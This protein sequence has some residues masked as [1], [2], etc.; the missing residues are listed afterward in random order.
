[1]IFYK[2]CNPIIHLGRVMLYVWSSPPVVCLSWRVPWAS[3][4][5]PATILI[6]R[7]LYHTL[8]NL[9]PSI[10]RGCMNTLVQWCSLVTR[11]YSNM[12]RKESEAVP[13]GNSPVPQQEEFGSTSPRWRMYIDFVSKDSK[14]S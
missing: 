12:P 14:Y 8:K 3:D 6:I 1:M 5:Y 7:P 4:E 9:S 2:I 11:L 13:E 10:W